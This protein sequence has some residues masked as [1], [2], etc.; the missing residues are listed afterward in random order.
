MLLTT[1]SPHEQGWPPSAWLGPAARWGHVLTMSPAKLLQ[2]EC[3]TEW[4]RR[5]ADYV[6][7]SSPPAS[8]AV[9]KVKVPHSSC[10]V[11]PRAR[12]LRA[13]VGQVRVKS[14]S[15]S[16]KTGQGQGRVEGPLASA[17]GWPHAAIPPGQ[18]VGASGLEL[19]RP[20][21]TEAVCWPGD[22]E[23]DVRSPTLPS[24]EHCLLPTGRPARTAQPSVLAAQS[25]ATCLS[26]SVRSTE[27][28]LDPPP[29]E[30]PERGRQTRGPLWPPRRPPQAVAAC[31]PWSPKLFGI[32]IPNGTRGSRNRPSRAGTRAEGLGARM[33]AAAGGLPPRPPR[34]AAPRRG[35]PAARPRRD[36][37]QLLTYFG[38]SCGSGSAGLRGA[39][40]LWCV[41][42]PRGRVSMPRG[43][44]LEPASGVIN[45]LQDRSLAAA[46]RAPH[47]RG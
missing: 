27:Q 2:R 32:C 9:P 21:H 30:Q 25:P 31:P 12:C 47:R 26:G 28:T 46:T 4:G 10:G 37:A 35:P 19:G 36:A 7:P 42:R 11:E 39:D 6:A 40:Q 1:R 18:P 8:M 44:G 20:G 45:R 38:K 14:L 17:R 33:D 34:P 22:L 23:R 43:S 24:W 3:Q 41:L 13:T 29:N 15:P 5:R 16:V